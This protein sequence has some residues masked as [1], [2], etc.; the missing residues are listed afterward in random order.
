VISK[1]ESGGNVEAALKRMK[2]SK[3]RKPI[4]VL[5]DERE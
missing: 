3:V 4:M 1:S 2:Y 5:P